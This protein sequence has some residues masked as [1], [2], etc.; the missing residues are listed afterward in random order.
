MSG[1]W[2][3]GGSHGGW[4]MIVT[5]GKYDLKKQMRPIQKH[6]SYLQTRQLLCCEMHATRLSVSH[7]GGF[8][9]LDL[10]AHV[11]MHLYK[12]TFMFRRMYTVHTS[13]TSYVWL[14]QRRI[15]S[16]TVTNS[17]WQP[18]TK[19]AHTLT[20]NLWGR[21]GVRGGG[22]PSSRPPQLSPSYH[23]FTPSFTNLFLLLSEPL[24]PQT[25]SPLTCFQVVFFFF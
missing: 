24:S 13:R 6:P 14:I 11:F 5:I 15:R 10:H 7:R 16:L 2:A 19:K 20:P 9:V 25:P 18:N 12:H 22:W 4:L 1:K 3:G 21:L 8:L 17:C 23:L